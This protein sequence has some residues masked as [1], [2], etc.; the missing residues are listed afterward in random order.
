MDAKELTKE[1]T[2]L[3]QEYIDTKKTVSYLE[4]EVAKLRLLVDDM[5]IDIKMLSGKGTR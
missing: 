4:D 2:K 1:Y 3:R 5:A